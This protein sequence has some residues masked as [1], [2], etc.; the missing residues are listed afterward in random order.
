MDLIRRVRRPK[1]M[2]GTTAY[3]KHQVTRAT[4][5]ACNQPGHSKTGLDERALLV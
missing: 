1:R 3:D 2:L 5:W 4:G